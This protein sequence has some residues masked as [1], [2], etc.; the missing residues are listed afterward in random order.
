[1]SRP[2]SAIGL[3]ERLRV[4]HASRVV[5][6]LIWDFDGMLAHRV[7]EWPA[8]TQVL[9]EVLDRETPGHDVD[10]A[11]L[12]PFLRTGF[13]WHSPEVHHPHLASA[14]VKRGEV[15]ATGTTK[16]TVTVT[17]AVG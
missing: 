11:L 9:L 8:G 15:F 10:P 5:R 6:W 13:P 7:C 17:Q 16:L 3:A 14:D 1:M 12:R 2:A 4:W